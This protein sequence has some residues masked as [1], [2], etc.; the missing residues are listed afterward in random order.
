MP[1]IN[2]ESELLILNIDPRSIS[3]SFENNFEI[4]K[5]FIALHKKYNELKHMC[6]DNEFI[7]FHNKLTSNDN[8]SCL[9]YTGLEPKIK[10][11]YAKPGKV[12]KYKDA[13]Q[14]MYEK[15]MYKKAII[16]YKIVKTKIS[17]D[18]NNDKKRLVSYLFHVR[19]NNHFNVSLNECRIDD[20]KSK[21]LYILIP[22]GYD[23]FH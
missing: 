19:L 6:K 3:K 21:H 22:L 16:E 5:S 14:Q 20:N 7:V 17:C 13:I 10:E 18:K 4:L 11:K 2:F 12:Q 23:D 9:F 15:Y 1:E 8:N